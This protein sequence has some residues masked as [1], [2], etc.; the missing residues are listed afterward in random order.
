VTPASGDTPALPDAD[1]LMAEI[2]REVRARRRRGEIPAELEAELDAAFDAVAP[3]G[4]TGSG[5][6]GA[7]DRA[8][9]QAVAV[10]NAPLPGSRYPG[11]PYARRALV[12]V[13]APVL[14]QTVG[15][16]LA[17]SRAVRI[18]G[19]RVDAL[20]AASASHDPALALAAA[21]VDDDLDPGPWAAAVTAHLRGAGGR[22][23][24]ADCG[25]G[26]L[27]VALADAGLDVYGVDPRGTAAEAADARAI[28]VRTTP[29]V[30]HLRSV[31]PGALAGLVLS[32]CVDRDARAAQLALVDAAS[33]ALA[34]G[35][36]LVVLGTDPV[37]WDGA[38]DPVAVDLSPGRPMHGETWAFVL[39]RRGFDVRGPD[40]DPGRAPGTY[41]VWAHRSAT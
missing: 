10:T 41:A 27:C 12:R 31:A 17:F 2:E 19:E 13:L 14:H 22:V 33:R 24:H 3:P 38:H 29:A 7:L 36:P 4:A 26:D 11:L 9:R 23:A 8:E 6:E 35:A 1:A 21:R 40:R 37:A 32:G 34:P 20:E 18:L 30:E 5:F 39:A 15:F 25:R 28:E 16:A